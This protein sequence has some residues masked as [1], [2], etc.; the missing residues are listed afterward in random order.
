MNNPHQLAAQHWKTRTRR[1]TAFLKANGLWDQY[2]QWCKKEYPSEYDED[3]EPV[4]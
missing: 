3:S 4:V 1:L 2:D